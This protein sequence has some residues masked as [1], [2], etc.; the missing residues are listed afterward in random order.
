M[1][2]RVVAQRFAYLV[3]VTAAVALML[4]G[5]AENLFVERLRAVVTDA[6]APILAVIS[7]PVAA[8][9]RAVGAVEELVYL[10]SENKRLRV[11][12]QR[13][14]GWEAAA[15]KLEQENAAF[16]AMLNMRGEAEIQG[17]ISARVIGDSGGPFVRTMLLDAGARMG[18]AKGQ[19]AVSG[20][21]VVGRVVEA[22]QRS[23]R[24]LLVTDLNSRIPVVLES[25]RYRAILAGDNSDQPRLVFSAAGDRVRPGD[26]IVTSGHGGVFPP[27]LPV[28]VV[29]SVADGVPRVQPFVDWHRLEYVEV[30]AYGPGPPRVEGLVDGPVRSW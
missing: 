21:G 4:L 12:N 24:V 8:V 5:K 6:A 29:V 13:L 20:K 23:A 15:R 10:H 25:S 28:G 2:A 7:E 30:L 17:A 11:D 27:G 19:P 1:S 26:R 18:V 16:R 14:R 3:L 22:G 9:E